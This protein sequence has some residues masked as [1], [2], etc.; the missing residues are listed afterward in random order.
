MEFLVASLLV[1]IVC[2]VV[3]HRTVSEIRLGWL[4][5]KRTARNEGMRF[6]NCDHCEVRDFSRS[7]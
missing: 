4:R 5:T 7:S 6:Q 2:G 1:G 3:L